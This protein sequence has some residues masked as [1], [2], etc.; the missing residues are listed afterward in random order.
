[1]VKYGVLFEV[2]AVLLNAI[3]TGLGIKG[4]VI[5]YNFLTILLML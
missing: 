2:R 4:L 1:M 3:W 5:G